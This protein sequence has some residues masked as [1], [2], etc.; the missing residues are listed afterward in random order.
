MLYQRL[1]MNK[2]ILIIDNEEAILDMMKMALTDE[3]FQIETSDTA[4]HIFSLLSKH[5]PDLVLIDYMLHDINGG[6]IC[7]QIKSNPETTHLPVIIFSGHG[8]VLRSLGTYNSDAIIEKPFDL[9]ELV[10]TVNRLLA[11]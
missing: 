3:G 9:L 5:S 11:A 1:D 2:K 4:D 6:E 10:D 8:R 7:H